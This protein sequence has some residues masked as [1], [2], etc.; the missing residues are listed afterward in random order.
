[1]CVSIDVAEICEC[2]DLESG[3]RSIDVRVSSRAIPEVGV[4]SSWIIDFVRS[5]E[6][7]V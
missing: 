4:T 3:V 5:D 2:R 1:M 7:F 6:D